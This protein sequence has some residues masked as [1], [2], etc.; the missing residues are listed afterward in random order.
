MLGANPR[1][2]IKGGIPH[3]AKIVMKA[4]AQ[5]PLKTLEIVLLAILLNAAETVIQQLVVVMLGGKIFFPFG[6]AF[7]KIQLQSRGLPNLV[8]RCL[9]QHFAEFMDLWIFK[10]RVSP[11]DGDKTQKSS[12]I[13]SS[14]SSLANGS[15]VT[16]PSL[17]KNS[18]R[19]RK[20]LRTNV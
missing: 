7:K 4:F 18:L 11:L 20:A 15:L 1:T 12:N 5:C 16:L 8:I 17:I 2:G 19:C 13:R 9:G 3:V 10:H 14:L 6:V